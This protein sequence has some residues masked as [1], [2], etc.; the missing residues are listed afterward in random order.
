MDYHIGPGFEGEM[1]QQE[2]YGGAG[3]FNMDQLKRGISAARKGVGYAKKLQPLLENLK[4]TQFEKYGNMA[5]S[6]L[7]YADKADSMLQAFGMG[8]K[9]RGLSAAMS[10]RNAKVKQI[11]RAK[12]VSLPE[13]SRI[14]KRMGH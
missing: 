1:P 13:A 14:L 7:G 3:G 9:R 11:M 5:D 4:G 2:M 10:A 8:R 6:A 12:G